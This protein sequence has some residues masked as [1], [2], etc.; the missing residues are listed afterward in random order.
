M[1][2]NKIVP[3]P[4][5]HSFG[6]GPHINSNNI[7]PFKKAKKKKNRSKLTASAANNIR[8]LKD[9]GHE[10]DY[11]GGF[12][13]GDDGKLIPQLGIRKKQA[14][15]NNIRR[16]QESGHQLVIDDDDPKRLKI[17]KQFRPRA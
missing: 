2:R 9:S 14:K 4:R 17:I 1:A 8:Y 10:T 16:L 13:L 5:D 7:R 6:E 12:R 3:G 11:T 15:A